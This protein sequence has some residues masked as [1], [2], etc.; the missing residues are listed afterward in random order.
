[1]WDAVLDKLHSAGYDA[2]TVEL[3]T[4]SPPSTAPA[5]TMADDAA[6]IHGVIEALANDGKDV[7]M[8]VHS[9]GGIPGTQAVQSL[10]QIERKEQGKDGGIVGLVYVSS[11]LIN[12][13]ETSDDSFAE[14]SQPQEIFKVSV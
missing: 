11:L 12:A 10:T 13:G 8:V 1:M 7:L 5:K 3:Q 14:F 9:Y 6:H 4:V 2:L